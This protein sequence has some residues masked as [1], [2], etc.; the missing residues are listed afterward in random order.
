MMRMMPHASGTPVGEAGAAYWGACWGACGGPAGGAWWVVAII[1]VVAGAGG[2]SA[3]QQEAKVVRYK[4][5]LSNIADA[6]FGDESVPINPNAGYVDPTQLA[7]SS[8]VIE[9]P[10][11][12]KTLIAKSVQHMMIHLQRCLDEEAD[13]LLI[14][15]VMSQK[16]ADHFR[17]EGKSPMELVDSLK[18]NRREIGRT[19]SRMPLGEHS[20]TVIL[21][22]PGDK[23][24]IIKVTG[25]AAKDLKFTRLW[26][27][28]E[29]G[30]WRFLWLD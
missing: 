5:F 7:E 19:F 15:Q 6:K 8:I 2:M 16:T 11:G 28:L 30:N 9:H 14:D 4:P 21:N 27:R 18:K 29:S 23:T 25:A 3:C 13:D 17:A 22:Q 20:P 1:C 24:W 12:S 26:A 10:D